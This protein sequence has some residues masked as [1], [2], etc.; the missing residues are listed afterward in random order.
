MEYILA[1]LMGITCAVFVLAMLYTKNSKRLTVLGRLEEYTRETEGSFLPQELTAPLRERLGRLLLQF[2]TRIS[3]KLV[4]GNKKEAYSSKLQAAGNLGGIN[5]ETFL[6]L[7]YLFLLSMIITGIWT[8]SILYFTMMLA[9]GWFV[10]D[11]Y[12]KSKENRRRSQILKSLPDVLDLLSVSVEAGLGFDAALQK[13]I[14]KYPGA[15]SNEFEKTLQEINIGKHRKE[16]LRDMGE[17]VGVDD[18]TTFLVSIIQAE[19][20]G[21]SIGNVLRL[22]SR[23]LRTNRRMRAEEKAQQAP[24]KILIPLLLFIFPTILLVLLGPAVIQLIDTFK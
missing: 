10:P 9:L 23:Q 15:L 7:K 18:L 11:L 13:V 4:P 12:L 2:F 21:V 1:C 24:V 22:Q 19:Q 14:D 6:M 3:G 8:R 20:L 17:R 16:A 5:A